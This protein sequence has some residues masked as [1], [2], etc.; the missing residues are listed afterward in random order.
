[1]H[2]TRPAQETPKRL[3]VRAASSR[4]KEPQQLVQAALY[5]DGHSGYASAAAPSARFLR[6]CSGGCRANK[7]REVHLVHAEMHAE[8]KAELPNILN[9]V[10]DYRCLPEESHWNAW[11]GLLF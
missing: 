2:R 4:D 10:R 3:L 9:A 6:F 1:M 5:A 7:C 8:H 11:R